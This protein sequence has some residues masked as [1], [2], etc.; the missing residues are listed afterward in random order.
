MSTLV[1]WGYLFAHKGGL[2]WRGYVCGKVKGRH[3]QPIAAQRWTLKP[4]CMGALR[5][6]PRHFDGAPY[7]L[8]YGGVV[9]RERF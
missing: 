8:K 9:E 7:M 4:F 3:P 5:P 1:L 2:A 6:I